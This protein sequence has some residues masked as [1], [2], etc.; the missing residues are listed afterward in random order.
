MRYTIRYERKTICD[1]YL[2]LITMYSAISDKQS[3]IK[4][5]FSVIR[6]SH[7]ALGC[8][9]KC[10]SYLLHH[11][12]PI[13]KMKM[14]NMRGKYVKMAQVKYL[15]GVTCHQWNKSWLVIDLGTVN[16]RWTLL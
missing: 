1:M 12:L 8:G 5:P 2:N 13:C 9:Y 3:V 10:M 15:K 4:K 14:A 11:N 6:R 7:F 16:A